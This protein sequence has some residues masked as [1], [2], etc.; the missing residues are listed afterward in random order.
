MVAA[1]YN[2]DCNP[3]PGPFGSSDSNVKPPLGS[4][5]YRPLLGPGRGVFPSI[6]FCN[7]STVSFS[8][9]SSCDAE[10]NGKHS[11]RSI[12]SHKTKSNV[13]IT[14][15]VVIINCHHWCINTGTQTFDF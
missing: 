14:Y 3:N 6:K 8:V 15:V 12:N 13:C 1:I 5:A 10:R 4:E 7:I 9:K 11:I 2:P